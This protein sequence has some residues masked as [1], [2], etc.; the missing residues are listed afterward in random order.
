VLVDLNICD[1]NLSFLSSQLIQDSSESSFLC[2]PLIVGSYEPDPGHVTVPGIGVSFE[3]C[4][5]VWS[6]ETKVNQN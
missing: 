3:D 5:A 4:E 2:D 1:W 6:V